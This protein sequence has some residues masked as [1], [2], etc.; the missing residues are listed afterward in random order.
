ML[1]LFLPLFD[2]DFPN[3]YRNEIAF[4]HLKDKKCLPKNTNLS[5]KN[6]ENIVPYFF[7][8]LCRRILIKFK[9]LINFNLSP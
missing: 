2:N 5:K 6:R 8:I 3:S 1:C 9:I 7:L 4:N